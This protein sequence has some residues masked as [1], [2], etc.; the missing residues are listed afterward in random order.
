MKAPWLDKVPASWDVRRLAWLGKWI[1]G[2]TPS[3]SDPAYWDGEIPWVSPKDM[4]GRVLKDTADHV[5]VAGVQQSSTRVVPA[6][7]VLIV[8]RSGILRHSLPVGIISRPM[9]FNQD[10]KALQPSSGIDAS[11]VAYWIEANQ[12]ALLS[13]WRKEGTTVQSLETDLIRETPIPLPPYDQQRGITSFLDR[14]TAR[15]GTLIEKKRRLLNLL[16]EK[17]TALITRAV[18]RGLDPD[19]P[20]KDSGVE[21]IG[22]IPEHWKVLQLRRV[23]RLVTSGSRGWAEHYA[24]EGALFIRIG[25]L[26]QDSPDLDLS[27]S[28]HVD[29]PTGSEAERSRVKA[30]D[31]LVSITALIGAIAVVPDGLEAYVNQHVALCRLDQRSTN[32]RWAAYFLLS[33]V[34]QATMRLP[35]YGGT[36]EGLALDDVRAFWVV[37]PPREEQ[38]G[39][40]G[41]LDERLDDL[42]K[43]GRKT[44]KAISLLE[45]Y[46]AALISAAVTGA[47][48]PTNSGLGD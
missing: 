10:I 5:S 41:W 43:I 42:G 26:S 30:G 9:A 28:Q 3:K 1:G 11:F 7:S 19:V 44:R 21:W 20:M 38:E 40:A 18:T 29:V 12:P 2:G 8:T 27:N 46:R 34:G 48:H 33:R 13:L 14:E 47:I 16:E 17:R 23:L 22:E 25:N 45:E 15:I 32:P 35:V 31:L 36:K 4:K 6:E 37:L 24:D 39:I